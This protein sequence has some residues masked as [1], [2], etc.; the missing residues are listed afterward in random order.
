[1]RAHWSQGV[2]ALADPGLAQT[3]RSPMKIHG[4]DE[5][6]DHPVEGLQKPS[7]RPFAFA[8]SC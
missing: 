4:I 8:F 1:M 2:E 3:F 5:V 7:R 6:D